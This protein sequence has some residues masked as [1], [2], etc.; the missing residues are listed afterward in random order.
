MNEAPSKKVIE[1]ARDEQRRKRIE[2][3]REQRQEKEKR[4]PTTI[5]GPPPAL[6]EKLANEKVRQRNLGNPKKVKLKVMPRPWLSGFE[7]I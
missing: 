5:S 2:E 4:P 3:R 1:Q 6:A 7:H